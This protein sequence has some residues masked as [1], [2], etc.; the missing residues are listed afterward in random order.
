VC[1]FILFFVLSCV[2]RGL[3]TGWSPVQGD[4]PTVQKSRNWIETSVYECPYAPEGVKGE[5]C[6]ERD[7]NFLK[8]L[9]WKFVTWTLFLDEFAAT[10]KLP[11]SSLVTILTE[12]T[13]F[14]RMTMAIFYY[15]FT[16]PVELSSNLHSPHQLSIWLLQYRVLKLIYLN[17]PKCKFTKFREFSLLILYFSSHVMFFKYSFIFSTHLMCRYPIIFSNMTLLIHFIFW[18]T[19]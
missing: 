19:E 9:T 8:A 13:R 10:P 6:R 16:L 5:K 7:I 2:D 17:L 3:A 4:L 12:L 1:V 15:R 18:H 11:T 14:T